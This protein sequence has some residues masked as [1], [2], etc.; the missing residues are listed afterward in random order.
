MAASAILSVT[1][2]PVLM[3]WLIRGKIP[4]EQ[5][6]P[7]NRGLTRAYRP[8]LDW[9]MERPKTTL[10]IAALVFATTAWPLSRLGGAFLPPMNEGDLLY[11]PSALPASPDKR[12]VGTECVSTGS[13]R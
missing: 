2:V 9:V 7:I 8:A 10:V 1:L 6:N 5:A 12:R 11:M 3:G 13:D 4:S